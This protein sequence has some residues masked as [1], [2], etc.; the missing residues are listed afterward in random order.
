M[1]YVAIVTVLALGEFFW[2][3]VMVARARARYGVHAPATTGNES[4]ERYYRV[5]MNTLEQLIVLL[6]VMWIF[7]SFVSPIWAAVGGAVFIIGRAVYAVAY[8]GD[9]RRRTLGF[10]LSALPVL[11]M[12]LGILIWGVRA[13]VLE[14]AAT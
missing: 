13:L 11:L 12:M 9:P 14:A 5:H 3:G 1:P 8:I 7:A 2:F 10:S 6:P 4:F